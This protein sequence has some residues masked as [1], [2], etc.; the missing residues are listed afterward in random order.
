MRW[1]ACRKRSS[2]N[3][4]GRKGAGRAWAKLYPNSQAYERGTLDVGDGHQIYYEQHG[5][6]SGKPALVVHGGPGAGCYA[7]H[8][9]FFDPGHYRIVLLDQRGCGKSTPRGQLVENTTA[10]L[11][12]DMKRLQDH[13]EIQS[14]VLFGGSWGVTLSLA[15]ACAYPERTEAM[16]LRGICL[17]RPLEIDWTFGGGASVLRP[18]AWSRFLEH[19]EEMEREDPLKSYHKR[20]LSED[21]QV[22]DAATKAWQSWEMSLFITP[23]DVTQVWDG[24]KWEFQSTQQNGGKEDKGPSSQPSKPEP[25]KENAEVPQPAIEGSAD[26]NMPS[27]VAQAMLTAHYSINHAFLDPNYLLDNVDRFRH[28]PTI[29]VHGMYDLVCPLRTAYD[30]HERWPEAELRIVSGGHSMYDPAVQ[31]ELVRSLDQ[32]R[33]K[34]PI[35]PTPMR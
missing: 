7:K 23:R 30:L 1:N 24:K 6:R 29:M 14:W 21:S 19:L 5:N 3:E 8:A 15:F 35:R 28:I 25:K 11:V 32:I 17:M 33:D 18:K 31:A 27:S 10:H 4:S 9:Q 16:V 20:L 22:R 34:K 13:L 12:Q 2:M 26:P